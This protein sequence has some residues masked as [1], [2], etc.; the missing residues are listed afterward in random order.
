VELIDFLQKLMKLKQSDPAEWPPWVAVTGSCGYQKDLLLRQ[1]SMKLRVF[2]LDKKSKKSFEEISAPSLFQEVQAVWLS[3][4]QYFQYVIDNL[5]NWRHLR[6]FV[7]TDSRGLVKIKDKAFLTLTC[8]KLRSKRD[9]VANH[10]ALAQFFGV[11]FQPDALAEVS[12]YIEDQWA[13]YEHILKNL[14]LAYGQQLITKDMMSTFLQMPAEQ[15][16]FQLRDYL[17]NKSATLSREFLRELSVQGEDKLPVL[18]F[19]AKHCRLALDLE[20]PSSSY[21]GRFYGG[22]SIKQRN[23]AQRLLGGI[24]QADLSIKNGAASSEFLLYAKL[25]KTCEQKR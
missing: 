7:I 5:P 25:V 2:H 11:S 20:T 1:I 6:F 21:I 13:S 19:M 4:V 24:A 22:L 14:E 10:K 16:V 18:G 12:R 8:E 23:Q 15:T 9:F 3:D 17:L